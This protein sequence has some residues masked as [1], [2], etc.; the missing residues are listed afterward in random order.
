MLEDDLKEKDEF[1]L[2][3]KIVLG[4]IASAAMNLINSSPPPP[5]QKRRPLPFLLSLSFF[6]EYEYSVKGVYEYEYSVMGM[7]RPLAYCFLDRK[8]LLPNLQ[9]WILMGT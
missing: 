4:K 8:T 9:M 6:Y 2:F 5:K 7:A 3:F 1:T